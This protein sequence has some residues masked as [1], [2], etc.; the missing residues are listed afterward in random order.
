MNALYEAWL[1]AKADEAQ[2]VEIRRAIEDKITAELAIAADA[3]GTITA[4][5]DGYTIKA[6]CRLNRKIDGDKLQELAAEHGLTLHLTSLFRWKPELSMKEWKAAAPDITAPLSG[7]ITTTA[8]RPSYS[9][10]KEDS[11]NG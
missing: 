10:V 11:N 4:K 5:R 7:A 8:G 9:I 2:A 3:D 1:K 6:T